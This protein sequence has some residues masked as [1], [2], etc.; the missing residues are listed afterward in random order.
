MS[1]LRGW[2]FTHFLVPAVMGSYSLQQ[3]QATE[4]MDMDEEEI[5]AFSD[6]DDG[7]TQMME[8]SDE[9]D[10]LFGDGAD[11]AALPDI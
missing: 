7:K 11:L 2:T 5:E 10:D 1:R 8:A 6:E 9:F 3:V 4:S